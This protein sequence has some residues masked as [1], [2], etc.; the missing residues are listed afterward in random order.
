MPIST[1]VADN[2][3]L[4]SIRSLSPLLIGFRVRFQPI[5]FNWSSFQDCE[6]VHKLQ[7]SPPWNR[8]GLWSQPFADEVVTDVIVIFSCP[9][10]MG[11]SS[12]EIPT[13]VEFVE[14]RLAS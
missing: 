10:S 2:L 9:L 6:C 1:W 13:F 3:D 14:R 11:S 12:H 5:L 8:H 4:S 7:L